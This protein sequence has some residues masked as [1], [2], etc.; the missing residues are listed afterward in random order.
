[1]FRVLAMKFV[2][3]TLYIVFFLVLLFI[4]TGIVWGVLLS[5]PAHPDCAGFNCLDTGFI[6]VIGALLM[7]TVISLIVT[8]YLYWRLEIRQSRQKHKAD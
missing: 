3:L 2:R 4:L 8:G 5:L 6:A 1:M 7:N